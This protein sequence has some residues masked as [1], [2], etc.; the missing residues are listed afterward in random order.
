MRDDMHTLYEHDLFKI[1]LIIIEIGRL[2]K[3]FKLELV[4]GSYKIENDI[5]NTECLSNYTQYQN[6]SKLSQGTMQFSYYLL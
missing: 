3:L 4:V 1:V 6:S 2:E 5:R